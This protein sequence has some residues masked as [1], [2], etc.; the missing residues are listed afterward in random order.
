MPRLRFLSAAAALLAAF[1]SSSSVCSASDPV[2]VPVATPAKSI[3]W[4]V[5]LR[6]TYL[7]TVDE[8]SSALL[9][10]NTLSV[11]DKWIPEFDIDY[12]FNEH[13][14]LELVLTVP[15]EHTVDLQGVGEIGDFEHLPPTLL[16]KYHA[17]SAGSRF[18]PYVGAGVNVTFIMDDDLNV[19]G[20]NPK[21]DSY[22][23]GPAGQIGCDVRLADR[24]TL[25]LD[26]KRAMIRSDVKIDGATVA[27]VRLDP[28]LYAV[29]L[30][31]AF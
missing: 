27:E 20:L 21:L 6:A 25:N 23:V 16:V 31:Y 2:V 17:L 7:E 19:A 3:P 22:S 28:W 4:S 11:S 10:E 29:G 8:S 14:S 30:E 18:R 24:W 15:Q 9:G 26:V 5:R 1:V 13:W 12:R